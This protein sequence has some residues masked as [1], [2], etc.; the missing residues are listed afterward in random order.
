MQLYITSSV[1]AL[2]AFRADPTK[3]DVVIT[4]LAMPNMSGD[5]LAGEL[6]KIRP[7]IPVILCTGFSERMPEEKAA[8]V[9]I[10]GFLM[11]P[12]VI[13]DLSS[14][15][16]IPLPFSTGWTLLSRY[17][18]YHVLFLW[19]VLT[20]DGLLSNDPVYLL[21]GRMLQLCVDWLLRIDW[22]RT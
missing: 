17:P 2:E 1:E 18:N 21:I 14:Q 3:F 7:D 5:K 8:A 19:T 13:K 20:L 10:K 12:I 11:K 16:V 4:D 6:I 15:R 22:L 9:G